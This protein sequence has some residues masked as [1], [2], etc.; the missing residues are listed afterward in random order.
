MLRWQE[1]RRALRADVARAVQ[2]TLNADDR[3]KN[4]VEYHVTAVQLG[5]QSDTNV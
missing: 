2:N 1:E 4:A 5:S 3:L